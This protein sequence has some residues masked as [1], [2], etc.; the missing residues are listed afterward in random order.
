MPK[1]RVSLQ[2]PRKKN[3]NN[4]IKMGA[5]SVAGCLR[6]KLQRNTSVDLQMQH[7][8]NKRNFKYS[9]GASYAATLL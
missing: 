1:T 9:T 6:I 2:P 4:K 7:T 8:F 3:T 5:A